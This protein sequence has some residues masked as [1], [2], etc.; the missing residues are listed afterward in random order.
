MELKLNGDQY[1]VQYDFPFNLLFEENGIQ[2]IAALVQGFVKGFS[3]SSAVVSWLLMEVVTP[4][5]APVI[6]ADIVNL[7]LDI[8]GISNSSQV[9]EINRATEKLLVEGLHEKSN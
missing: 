5:R 3:V 9:N 2:N 1:G 4:E 7:I 6:M 8:A